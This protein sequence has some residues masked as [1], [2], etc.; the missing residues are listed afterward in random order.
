M[1]KGILL[2]YGGTIDTNGLHWA[3]VLKSN[4]I[5][6]GIELPDDVFAKAYAYGE[7]ALAIHP[8]VKPS[9]TFLDV[10]LLKIEQQFTYLREQGYAISTTKIEPIAS[11][12]TRFAKETVATAVPVLAQLQKDFPLVM[13]SNFYGNLNSVL[14][15]FGI[16]KYFNH[17]VE[18]AVVGVR[19][20]DP[21]IYQIG[22]NLLGLAAHEC[23][24]V[25]D[26]FAKDIVPAQKLG[27]K[28]VWLK[29][30]GWEEDAPAEGMA[31]DLEVSSF[32]E[33]PALLIATT[34]Y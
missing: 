8:L 7:K 26:S 17:V 10:L 12:C 15:D 14:E 32:S 21:A 33:V 18:S 19:K 16:R 23:I 5:N 13:V 31:A 30:K 29:A 4:Y 27:C 6:Q 34:N 11:S 28:S 24:V 20:P 9:H 25:G 3:V 2:D 22:V 1:I